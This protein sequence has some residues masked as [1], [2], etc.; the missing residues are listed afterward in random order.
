MADS[1]T[2]FLMYHELER[3]GRALCQPGPGYAR[4]AVS[5]SDFRDQMKSLREDGWQGI[6]VTQFLTLAPAK[7]VTITFDDGVETDL[8]CGAPVLKEAGF[9][10]T[11]YVTVSWVGKPGYLTPSQLRELCDLGLEIGCH[12]ATHPYL[13]DIDDRQLHEETAAAK[14]LLEQITGRAVNH[15]SCPGGRW[16]R[17]VLKAVKTAQFQSMATSHTIVNSS[18]TDPF[19]L[20]RV[21]VLRSTGPEAFARTCRGEGLLGARL[22][23]ATRGAAARLL[24]NS[25]YDSLRSWLL[26]REGS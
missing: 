15:F 20:G 22:L 2:V 6:N 8:L 18:Q 7:S 16:D 3:L 14:N 10:A 1:G 23:E 5:E 4:Y 13:T 9:G 17:R 26:G 12:S 25:A 21:A 11:F 19:M 24:G